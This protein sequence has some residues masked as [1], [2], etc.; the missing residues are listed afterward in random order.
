MKNLLIY[1]AIAVCLMS[2]VENKKYNN[3]IESDYEMGYEN[4]KEVEPEWI[5]FETYSDNRIAYINSSIKTENDDSFVVWIKYEWADSTMIPEGS[6]RIRESL[7]CYAFDIDFLMIKRLAH[8]DYTIDGAA[9]NEEDC[10]Y[11]DW[12]Y[13]IPDS[14]GENIANAAI[15]VLEGRYSKNHIANR[16][17]KNRNKKY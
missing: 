10:R 13:M 12:K 4:S 11:S 5:Q 2:C 6:R 7:N 8:Y 15:K 1:I 17:Y 16:I 9:I 14:E 3:E